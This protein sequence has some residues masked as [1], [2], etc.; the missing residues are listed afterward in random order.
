MN[1]RSISILYLCTSI[2]VGMVFLG[3]NNLKAEEPSVDSRDNT[4]VGK[5]I[6][7]ELEQKNKIEASGSLSFPKGN[8]LRLIML[9]NS[10][11]RPA[12]ETLPQIA[13]AAGLDGHRARACTP[14]S[15][16]GH[17]DPLFNSPEA[18]NN[19]F[20]AINTG[21]WDAMTI[22]SR[23]KDKPEHF[24]QWIDLG[25]KANSNMKF[26]IQTGWAPLSKGSVK[27]P[28]DAKVVIAQLEADL[29]NQK[30][31]YKANYEAL[32]VKYKGKVYMIP[33]GDAVLEMVRLYYDGKLPGVDCLSEKI[34]G[35]KKGV[36]MDEGHLGNDLHYL[37]G[38][39]FYATLYR[40]SPEEIKNFT[41]KDINPELDQIMRRVAWQAVINSPYSGVSDK[42]AK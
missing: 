29:A 8:G 11:T 36:F 27:S 37:L 13:A 17:A 39:L 9:G 30:M 42:N 38:Y 3:V 23:W 10:W 20:P 32:Q 34:V 40:V 28:Q 35:G 14:G 5:K 18:R 31:E 4:E 15:Q 25:L 22:L 2:M 6:H 1:K 16:R 21:Q 24:A 33:C 12:V 7:K 26:Y 41:P 19:I